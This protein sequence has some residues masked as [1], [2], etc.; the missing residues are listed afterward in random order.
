M[1]FF[2]NED[3]ALEIE[4][5]TFELSEEDLSFGVDF[6]VIV[7]KDINHEYYD[8]SYDVTP[9]VQSQTLKT[10]NKVCKK[11]ISVQEIPK[12]DVSNSKGTTVYIGS[13]II[14]Q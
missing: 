11:D 3:L 4:D 14:W 1:Y 5:S 13:E 2:L 6:G 8:G 7:E 10:A 9:K 12:Y